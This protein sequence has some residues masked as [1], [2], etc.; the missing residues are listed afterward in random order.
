MHPKCPPESH[1]LE[2]NPRTRNCSNCDRL[3]RIDHIN[4]R[5]RNFS[6]EKHEYVYQDHC[7]WCNIEYFRRLG[8]S[9]RVR[10]LAE[11]AERLQK[12]EKEMGAKQ[13]REARIREQQAEKNRLESD[14]TLR[15][16]R[17]MREW[18]KTDPG[19]LASACK[20]P[21]CPNH[22]VSTCHGSVSCLECCIM[23]GEH[24]Y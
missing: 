7:G 16:I 15:N 17:K 10:K 3:Y 6:L 12:L 5:R 11:E 2:K 19:Y 8:A 14:E 24:I 21:T 1:G 9:E 4:R 23:G 20:C 18:K 13:E 22:V